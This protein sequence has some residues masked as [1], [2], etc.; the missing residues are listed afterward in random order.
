MKK[1]SYL[2]YML[3]IILSISCSKDDVDNKNNKKQEKV[4][5]VLTIELCTPVDDI[6]EVEKSITLTWK[7][8]ADCFDIYCDE[9]EATLTKLNDVA[10]TDKKFV[11]NNLKPRTKYYWNIIARTDLQTK[12]SKTRSFTTKQRIVW[13]K[14]YGKK[15]S[16]DGIYFIDQIKSD[17]SFIIMGN[18]DGSFNCVSRVDEK[19]GKLIWE[20]IYDD[21]KTTLA[22]TRFIKDHK[23]GYAIFG[24][25]NAHAPYILTKI[26]E[27]GS[28]T[29]KKEIPVGSLHGSLHYMSLTRD[30]GYILAGSSSQGIDRNLDVWIAKLNADGEKEWENYYGSADS[31]E[32]ANSIR[33]TKDGGFIIAGGTDVLNRED[34]SER[35]DNIMML[36]V[37]N[38]GKYEWHKTFGESYDDDAL[39]VEQ[40][41][42]GG[43]VFACT[44][45]KNNDDIILLKINKNGSQEWDKFYGGNESDEL[46]SF[47]KTF[48]GGFAFAGTTRVNGKTAMWFTKVNEVGKV[49]IQETFGKFGSEMGRSLIQSKSGGYLIGGCGATSAWLIKFDKT[50]S[51]K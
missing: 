45:T 26:D 6:K 41:S 8:N 24:R 36:K 48:D 31:K 16:G 43:Y 50:G 3:L 49:E 9:T 23:S 51:Y 38:S 33:E 17:G 46:F 39:F 10:I 11:V 27:N 19:E 2:L 21:Y 25:K 32:Y 22:V 40:T 47:I 42:D 20:K 7:S 13:S 14:N 12:T 30:G 35:S 28:V 34:Q 1:I 5:K 18:K 37:S 29:Y 4:D 44:T 15:G